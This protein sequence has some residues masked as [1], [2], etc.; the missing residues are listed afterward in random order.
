MSIFKKV[1]GAMDAKQTAVFPRSPERSRNIDSPCLQHLLK[2][3][4]MQLHTEISGFKC[5][6]A[7]HIGY[8]DSHSEASNSTY[9]DTG[10]Q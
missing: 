9:Q 6:P 4:S 2:T 8:F 1:V 7:L 10:F 3:S 5:F